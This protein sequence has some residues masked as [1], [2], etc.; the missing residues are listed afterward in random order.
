M[1]SKAF[2]ITTLLQT[3]EGNIDF[4]N[5]PAE[6][7]KTI[8]PILKYLQNEYNSNNL[9][10]GRERTTGTALL[11]D[12]R[13]GDEE[14]QRTPETGGETVDAG[15]EKGTDISGEEKEIKEKTPELIP[16]GSFKHTK[17]I[18]FDSPF[19]LS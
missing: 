12:E 15:A 8:E 18:F 4:G 6:T 11:S 13:T 14:I 10:R 17:N 7:Q 2:W 9:Q 19:V 3:Y 1:R 5:M 16:E